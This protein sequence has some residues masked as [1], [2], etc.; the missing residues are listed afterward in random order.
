MQKQMSR[1]TNRLQRDKTKIDLK[2]S[3]TERDAENLKK[4]LDDTKEKLKKKEA[5]NKENLEKIKKLERTAKT[6]GGDLEKLRKELE[7]FEGLRKDHDEVKKA[8][9]SSQ[10]EVVEITKKYTKEMLLRKKYYN[11]IEDMK[12]KVRVYCRS[13]PISK[14]EKERGN[15]SVI[16]APDEF[17]M[18]VSIL[19]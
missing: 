15:F 16:N 9:K 5:E 19:N 8:L 10:L 1:D 2:A 3:K 7:E 14:T 12:G 4:R 6:S 17:T 18:K 13:R 11:Q